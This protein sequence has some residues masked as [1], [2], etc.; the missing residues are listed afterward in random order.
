MDLST[1]ILDHID[2]LGTPGLSIAGIAF[3]AF[4]YL[5]KFSQDLR[6]APL[7]IK[8]KKF[9]TLSKTITSSDFEKTPG[10]ILELVFSQYFGLI[11]P[12]KEIHE[13]LKSDNQMETIVD[14][15]YCRQMLKFDK[16][17]KTYE[18]KGKYPLRV[19]E[20]AAD[21]TYLLSSIM[22]IV[23]SV[24]ALFPGQWGYLIFTAVFSLCIY[25][26]WITLRSISAA[27]RVLGIV[28]RT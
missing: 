14:L 25:A 12:N 3:F 1:S 23:V 6:S 13:V 21:L 4:L 19:R 18:Y 22:L 7:A 28:P 20:I 2:K 24:L 8:D 15:K 26:S 17:N 5:L 27:K 9:E 10:I 11:L 16:E